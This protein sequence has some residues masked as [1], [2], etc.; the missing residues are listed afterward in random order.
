ML[1]GVPAAFCCW[2]NVTPKV[3]F[4][5]GAATETVHVSGVEPEAGVQFG[6]FGVRLATTGADSP[7]TE[8]EIDWVAGETYAGRPARLAAAELAGLWP[9]GI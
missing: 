3:S 6:E 9:P 2:N 7:L 8:I 4:P 1:S 5:T